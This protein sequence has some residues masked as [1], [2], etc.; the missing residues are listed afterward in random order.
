MKYFEYGKEQDKLAVLLHG[1]GT[2]YKGA[3]PTANL[4][5]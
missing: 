2:S 5:N 4:L 1:G 3:E